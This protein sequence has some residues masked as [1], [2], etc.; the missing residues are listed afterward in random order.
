MCSC[1]LDQTQEHV[2]DAPTLHVLFTKPHTPNVLHR[3]FPR[4][5]RQSQNGVITSVTSELSPQVAEDTVQIRD[6]LIAWIADEALG[7]DRQAAEWVLLSCISKV[8]VVPS[9]YLFF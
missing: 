4:I 1:G 7:G 5:V 2:T 8:S 6:E 9:L 3:R